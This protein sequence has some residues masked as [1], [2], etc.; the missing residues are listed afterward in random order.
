MDEPIK[1]SE[2]L[3]C[4]FNRIFGYSQLNES[5]LVVKLILKT[6]KNKLLKE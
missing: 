1:K 2:G 4:E 3:N 5:S 6:A